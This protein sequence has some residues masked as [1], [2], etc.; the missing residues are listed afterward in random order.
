[1]LFSRHRP[2]MPRLGILIGSAGGIDRIPN[3]GSGF[4]R[5]TRD[6]LMI[7]DW[8]DVRSSNRTMRGT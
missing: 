3:I 2:R 8:L 7:E 4:F 5:L 6:P 1:V